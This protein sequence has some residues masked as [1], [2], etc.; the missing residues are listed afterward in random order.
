MTTK[1]Q[2]LEQ[3]VAVLAGQAIATQQKLDASYE[4]EAERFE[5]TLQG[6]PPLLVELTLPLAPAR[7]VLRSFRMDVNVVITRSQGA[8]FALN[9]RPLNLG[10]ARAYHRTQRN[11]SRFAIDV[12]Q[13]PPRDASELLPKSS[14]N[15]R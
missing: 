14:L 10:Y 1:Q 12:E 2:N 15:N 9:I 7:L 5:Q 8:S 4:Q 11:E 13:V 3:V 6:M